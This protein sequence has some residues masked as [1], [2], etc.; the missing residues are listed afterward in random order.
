M[1]DPSIMPLSREDVP[2]VSHWGRSVSAFECFWPEETLYRFVEDGLSYGIYAEG[3]TLVGF[4]LATYQ[5][6]TR[7][8]TWENLYIDPL[9]RGKGL[10]QK[11]FQKIWEVGRRR[12][13]LVAEGIVKGK[14]KS[15]ERMLLALGFQLTGHCRWY[16]KFS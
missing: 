9:Y 11:A 16:H 3:P 15:S 12:G 10:G 5:P 14:N 2:K 8:L 7:K 4:A 6:I 13:A 1:S